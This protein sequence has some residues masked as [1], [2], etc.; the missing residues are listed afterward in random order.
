MLRVLRVLEP[1]RLSLL[2]ERRSHAPRGADGGED[3]A[4]GRNRVN[5]R[6]VPA[7]VTLELEAGDV[8]S[9]E[10]PGGGGFGRPG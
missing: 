10:T 1:C 9:I 8:V 7:K 4:A 6:D 3:G 2:T 5:G